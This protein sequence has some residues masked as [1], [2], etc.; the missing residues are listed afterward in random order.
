MK[1]LFILI[2]IAISLS[3]CN[4]GVNPNTP[5]KMTKPFI[6][7]YKSSTSTYEAKYT[8]QDAN[9]NQQNFYDYVNKYSVGDTLK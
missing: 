9:G 1:K 4:N 2:A 8:Y 6:I 7:I 5:N 3:A